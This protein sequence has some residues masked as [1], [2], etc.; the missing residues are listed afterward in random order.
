[1]CEISIVHVEFPPSSFRVRGIL[2]FRVATNAPN[3]R[4]PQLKDFGT[5]SA[6]MF[7]IQLLRVG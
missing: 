2:S 3:L 5:A 7:R 4:F 1:M 6:N